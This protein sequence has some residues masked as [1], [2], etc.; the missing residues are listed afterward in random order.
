MKRYLSHIVFL[1]LMFLA[2]LYLYQYR[3][4][5]TLD[6]REMAFDISASGNVD[7]IIISN[8]EG[9]AALRRENG[10]WILNSRYK[11]RER[12]VELMLQ[13][14]S[15]LR[16]VSPAPMSVADELEN[17]FRDEATMVELRIGRKTR[18][19]LVYSGGSQFPTYMRFDRASQAF[20]MEVLGFSG[21]VASL[22]VSDEAYWRPNILFNYRMDEIAEVV[23]Q[24]RAPEEGSF[25]L[26]QTDKPEFTLYSYPE[27]N[28][29]ELISD[30]LAIRFL[31]G[32]FYTPFERFATPGE[33]LLNDSL[34]GAKPDHM[35]R[36][37]DRSGSEM[38]VHFHRI[39]TGGN[40]DAAEYD[41]F[42]LHALIT[43]KGEMVVVPYHSVDLL[44]R[45]ACYFNPH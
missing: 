10:E 9:T 26:R 45:S 39:V 3:K 44:L 37:T 20:V 23:V 1:V 25:L 33:K 15:R 31:S 13:T 12:A 42:R 19:Y 32:F 11:A 2:T 30:S 24:H 38:E 22:F 5:G 18:R 21:H 16:I 36:V 27:G 28:R 7:E 4:L 6:R 17:K 8:S 40:N 29:V 35:I 41:L 34:A 43:G 14:L